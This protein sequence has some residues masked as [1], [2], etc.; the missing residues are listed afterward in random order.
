[1]A[2]YFY[3]LFSLLLITTIGY[4][5]TIQGKIIDESSGEGLP[6]ANVILE[7]DGVQKAGTTTDLDGN[8]ILT[9]FDPGTYGVRVVY[10]GYQD[11]LING[12]TVGSSKTIPLDIQMAVPVDGGV[13]LSEIVVVEYR[14]PL[15][16]QDNT[17]SGTTVTA[18]EVMKMPVKSVTSVIATTAGVGQS[19]E[20]GATSFRGARENDDIIFVDGV[21]TRRSTVPAAD[22]EQVQVITGGLPAQYGDVTG[23]ITNI[24]TRGPSSKFSGNLELET[25]EFLDAYG[26]NSANLSFS[27]PLLTKK[28]SEG[29]VLRS[30]I[31]YRISGQYRNIDEAS[32]S[33]VGAYTAT[34]EFLDLMRE[35]PLIFRNN[36]YIPRGFFMSEEDVVLTKAR[37]NVGRMDLNG[38]GKVDIQPVSGLNFTVGG[39]YNFIDRAEDV[40]AERSWLLNSHKHLQRYD[41]DWRVF[42]RLRQ[43]IGGSGLEELSDEE[44]EERSSATIQNINYTIQVDYNKV[45]IERYDPDHKDNLFNYGY[46][47]QYDRSW[48]PAYGFNQDSMR[49]EQV[50]FSE[51]FDDFIPG[52]VNLAQEKYLGYD[53]DPSVQQI[54]QNGEMPSSLEYI[55]SSGMHYNY[56]A[57]RN[58]YFQKIEENQFGVTASGGLDIV[59][60]G[61]DKSKHSI[62]LGVIYEQRTDRAYDIFPAP[63]WQLGRQLVR[64]DWFLNTSDTIFSTTGD[65]IS[66]PLAY[67]NGSTFANSVRDMYSSEEYGHFNS[68]FLRPED[69][70]LDMFSADELNDNLPSIYLNYEGYDYTGKKLGADVSFEDFFTERDDRGDLYRPVA[71]FA[72]IYTAFFLQDKF[73]FRDIYFNLGVRVDRYDANTKVLADPYTFNPIKTVA[74]TSEL[75][76]ADGVED[77]WKVYAEESGGQTVPFAYR[78]GDTWYTASGA[79]INDPIAVYRGRDIGGSAL[80]SRYQNIQDENYD[81][82]GVFVDY[83]PQ[84]NVMPRVSFSFPISED[85]GFFAHYDILTRRPTTSNRMNALDYYNWV[86]RQNIY[87]NNNPDLKPSKTIDYQVGFQQKVSASSSVKLTAYY[88][89]QRSLIAAR[90]YTFADPVPTYV[91]FGNRDFGT[92]K[93]F[94]FQ[95]DL[96]RTKNFKFKLD[97]TLQFAEGTS[98]SATTSSRGTSQLG[99]VRPIFPYSFDQRHNIVGRIDFRYSEGD[100]YNGPKIAGKDILEN[101]GVNILAKFGSGR[102]YTRKQDPSPRSGTNTIGDFNGSRLPWTNQFDL[103]VDKDFFFGRKAGKKGLSLNVYLR[104]LNILNT[105]NIVGVYPYTQDPDNDGFLISAEGQTL[106]LSVES[107]QTYETLYNLRLLDDTNY[108]L[109]RRIRLGIITNF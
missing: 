12:I 105:G 48:T 41:Q 76:H 96:R 49:Y 33:F 68:D 9:G 64:S 109:P 98:S 34:D 65:T 63:L 83:E 29:K 88:R 30:I 90:T 95:Y 21:R 97:Y 56:G 35:D 32:P 72:P 53:I 16:E 27:G 47:G 40:R 81:P 61:K 66:F 4:G 26:Y 93:G 89:E 38:N 23:G 52:G 67:N 20:G 7:K 107:A 36:R 103:R 57:T 44:K 10:V 5:Q 54:P 37:P 102:P 73:T 51:T 13:N 11:K 2:R 55:Y 106:L 59:G 25:S 58:N 14:V 8:F 71:P 19:K 24:I 99:S 84:I 18:E 91:T 77:D 79:L 69:L 85:A 6:F 100:K 43:K 45:N 92:V 87:S 39:N 46:L 50:G 28:N 22:I 70:S 42:A 60:K 101:F 75:N 62:L 108:G 104:V 31:G 3:L 74:E 82:T 86:Q 94:T 17:A 15:I 1:M 78:D 80:Y